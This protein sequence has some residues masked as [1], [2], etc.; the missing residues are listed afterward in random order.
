MASPDISALAAYSGR[1]EKSLFSTLVNSLD[2]VSDVTLIQ[3]VKHTLNLTKLRA[4]D[5]ARPYSATFQ[6][7]G[8]DLQYT[9]RKLVVELGKRDL[10]I[11][12]M[13]YRSSFMAEQLSRGVNALEIPYAAYVWEQIV[14][15]LAAEINDKTIYFGF[16]KSTAAAYSA[17]TTYSV[18]DYITFTG[19]N[20]I[21]DYYK[22]ISATT[23][24]Q[25]P[26]THAAKWQKVNAEAICVGF[27]KLIADAITANSLT[28][29]ATGAITDA[30]A[31]GQF[32]EMYRS[33]PVAYQKA[34]VNIYGSF[35]SVYALQDDFESKVSKYTERDPATGEIYLAKTNRKCKVV[36][37]SWMG[38]SGRLIATPKENLLIGTDLLSDLNKIRTKENLRTLEVGIDF[39]LGTQIRDLDAIRVNNVA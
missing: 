12:P 37:A 32:T 16:D 20:G 22:C 11:E 39:A 5:G 4:G 14:K 34:G 17:A 2:A 27:A 33:L 10:E 25:S 15:E 21:T 9:N 13:K 8:T 1:Y 36:A 6:G 19:T 28:P 30:D 26:T 35:D 24:G 31:Y 3:D 23:A 38:S 7:T 18:G 29:V